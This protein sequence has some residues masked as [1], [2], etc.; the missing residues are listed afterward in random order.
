MSIIKK[1]RSE[2]ISIQNEI[3]NIYT[4]EFKSLKG[5]FKYSPGQFLHLALDSDYDGTGQWPESRCFSIQSN[6][7]QETIK[8]TY[9]VKG[10]FT[11]MM[12]NELKVGS[13]VWLKMPYGELFINEHDYNNTIFI[14][15]GTGITPF[16]SLFTDECFT[17]Y[18]NPILYA[19]FRNELMNIFNSELDAARLINHQLRIN[20]IYEDEDG[21]L[22]I[23]NI[24][25]ESNPS[26]CFFI[27]GPPDMI[28]T[29]RNYLLKNEVLSSNIITDDWE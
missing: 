20:C 19:G 8:L 16:L 18:N 25:K 17:K 7:N 14:A 5:K 10:V 15:G 21:I 11:N 3:E 13:I 29:F 24:H 6:S 2:L 28:T 22:S 9:S 1:Y 12:K 4:L 26:T 23:E 27:S